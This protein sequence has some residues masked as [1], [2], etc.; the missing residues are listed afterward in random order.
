FKINRKA[1]RAAL[2][3]ALSVHAGRGSIGA[4]D[5]GAFDAPK[6]AD[7]AAAL[8]K[9]DQG[10]PTLVALAADEVAA[11]KSFRNIERVVVRDAANVDI[12]DLIAAAAFLASDAAF[13]QLTARA[14]G[15]ADATTGSEASTEPAEEVSA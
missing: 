4:L 11:A 9:W 1:R 8:A 10:S 15:S 14:K 5:A 6:T 12:A 2:R 3:S 13:E 7:A